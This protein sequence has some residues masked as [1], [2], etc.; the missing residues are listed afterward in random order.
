MIIARLAAAAA[1][2]TLAGC[3]LT[4]GGQLLAVA[5]APKQVLDY[6]AEVRDD[7]A[8]LMQIRKLA[9]SSG[10]SYAFDITDIRHIRVADGQSWTTSAPTR[11]SIN[12]P[13]STTKGRHASAKRLAEAM[14]AYIKRRPDASYTT[15][16]VGGDGA[17][18]LEAV[19]ESRGVNVRRIPAPAG[20]AVIGFEAKPVLIRRV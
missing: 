19:M 17:E 10:M 5:P 7:T 9:T 1:I 12:L 2:I 13:P 14:A 15:A 8:T 18:W 3:T 16:T 6:R 4:D 11:M 20:T